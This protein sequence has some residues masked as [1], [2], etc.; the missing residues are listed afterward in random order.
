MHTMT[1]KMGLAESAATM[2]VYIQITF[3]VV[4][5]A[6]GLVCGRGL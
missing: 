2:A 6:M 5:L 3:I 1:R 4:C